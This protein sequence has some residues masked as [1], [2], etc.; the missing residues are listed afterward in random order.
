M[1][2]RAGGR[3]A[4]SCGDR[5]LLFGEA[6]TLWAS[7]ELEGTRRADRFLADVEPD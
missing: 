3:A 1:G 5:D 4:D 2:R 6:S 7:L